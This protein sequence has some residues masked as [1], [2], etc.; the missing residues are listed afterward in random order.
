MGL[1]QMPQ[2]LLVAL[3]VLT[4]CALILQTGTPPLAQTRGGAA[5]A[6]P[7]DPALRALNQGM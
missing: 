6:T 3:R 4:V 2:P 5:P 1:Q 7:A